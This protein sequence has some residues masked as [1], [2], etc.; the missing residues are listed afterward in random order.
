[1]GWLLPQ[2]AAQ[3]AG[4][5]PSRWNTPACS[6]MQPTAHM[7]VPA[8]AQMPPQDHAQGIQPQK[9]QVVRGASRQGP[10]EFP[11]RTNKPILPGGWR[12]GA[13]GTLHPA[14]SLSGFGKEGIRGFVVET[15]SSS[16]STGF[17]GAPTSH[18]PS[19]GRRL[20]ASHFTPN[21]LNGWRNCKQ[22]R[23][24][25]AVLPLGIN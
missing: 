10:Q 2:E 8:K 7:P 25:S 12:A 21:R 3:D 4:F 14:E 9:L 19:A 13:P 23:Q 15:N 1:M 22:L 24:L 18:A 11:D 5:L 17:R 16:R 20:S 6:P